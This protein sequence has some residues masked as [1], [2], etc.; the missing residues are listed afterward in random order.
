MTDPIVLTLDDEKIWQYPWLYLVEPSNLVLNE[1]DA[2]TLR[3]HLLR[4]GTL[5]LDDFHGPYEW[6]LTVRQ[7]KLIF[8]DRE[9]VEIEPPHPI[10]SVLLQDRQVPAGSGSRL[11]LL[12]AHLGEGRLR[13]A[14]AR[15]LDDS[16]R[17]MVLINWNTDMGDGV[18]WSNAEDYP[19]YVKWTAHGLPDDDQR[20]D[21]YAS[22][23]D[24]LNP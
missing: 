24:H 7:L 23:T 17:P 6:D 8:P 18:E 11:V 12:R 13:A 9:I 10:Y 4:G 2:A 3:E 20:G 14:P 19:G 5:T 21:L 1:K 16:G 22:R 15:I